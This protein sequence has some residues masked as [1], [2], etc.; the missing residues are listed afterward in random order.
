MIYIAHRGNVSGPSKMENHP[1]HITHALALDFNVEVDV[2]YIDG[3]FI[4]SH[5]HPTTA[6]FKGSIESYKAPE[7]Y[8]A[9]KKLW[10]HAKTI[11]TFYRLL[12]NNKIN[13]FFHNSD[14]CTLTSKGY[15]WTYPG[16][17]LTDKSIAVMPELVKEPYDFSKAY[18]VCSDYV[19]K[20]SEE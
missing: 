4:L 7:S 5:D 14:D 16:N 2:W 3:Q 20:Y 12:Q 9:N 10:C 18:G 13:C 11:E 17:D 1:L 15:I 6:N 19:M 8:L